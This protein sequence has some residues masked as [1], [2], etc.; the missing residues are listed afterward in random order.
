[1]HP[2]HIKQC[3]FFHRCDEDGIGAVKAMV[4]ASL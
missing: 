3:M 2:K 4:L 1:V